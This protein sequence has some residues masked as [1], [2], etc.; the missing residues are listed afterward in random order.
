MSLNRE[1]LSII[2]T[3]ILLSYII[4]LLIYN[5]SLFNNYF[6]TV[7]IFIIL[8]YVILLPLQVDKISNHFEQYLQFSNSVITIVLVLLTFV[9]VNNKN[10][11][12]QNRLT[13]AFYS[14]G[15]ML[16]FLFGTSLFSIL[17]KNMEQKTAKLIVCKIS[18]FMFI[19]SFAILISFISGLTLA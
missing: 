16:I 4:L 5:K 19:M 10:I 15:W 13:N 9:V 18:L 12:P 2:E 6:S 8:Y 3:I 14:V 11:I 1:E 17:G 7:T